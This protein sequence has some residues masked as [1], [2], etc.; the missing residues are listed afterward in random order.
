MVIVQPKR[1]F[2]FDRELA[3]TVAQTCSREVVGMQLLESQ[4]NECYQLSHIHSQS[5]NTFFHSLL[6]VSGID[7]V[8]YYTIQYSQF[9]LHRFCIHTCT[10]DA[11]DL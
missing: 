1:L 11:R 8:C 10:N 6:L 3:E 4:K 5:D 9:F 7:L 2:Q